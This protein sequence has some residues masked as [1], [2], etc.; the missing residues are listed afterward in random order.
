MQLLSRLIPQPSASAVGLDV[1]EQGL[2][3]VELRQS[4]AGLVL[5]RCG[6]EP[7]AP[8]CVVAG[9]VTE[10]EGVEAALRRL[11][12]AAGAAGH[13]G[14]KQTLAL[15]LAVPAEL[16][17]LRRAHFAGKPSAP[18]L[19]ELVQA[20]MASRLQLPP[21]EVCV[22]FQLGLARPA[23]PEPG[24]EVFAAA[25]PKELVE[26]RIALVEGA[27]LSLRPIVMAMDSQMAAL[28]ACRAIRARS[29][30]PGAAVAL[31][32]MGVD[33]CQ[34]DLIHQASIL[35]SERFALPPDGMRP[36]DASPE[37]C[38]GLPAGLLEAIESRQ[39]ADAAARPWQ[40]WVAG[41][42][43]EA[44]AWVALLQRRSSLP[45]G[46]LNPLDGMLR[47]EVLQGHGL[48]DASRTLV[49]CGLALAALDP[50]GAPA[51][52]PAG[53]SPAC[54]NFLPYRQIAVAQR[55][56]A[57]LLQ[58][59]AVALSVLLSSAVLWQLWSER[60]E[61]GQVAQ[62]E[63]RRESA[64]LDAEIRRL[65]AVAAEVAL[66]KRHEAA[67]ISFARERNQT[68]QMLHEL[69][70]LVPEGVQLISVRID[71]QGHASISG[72]AR[73]A[74]EVFG[75]IGR[76]SAG[77][78]FKQA[79]LLDLSS[80][81]DSGPAAAQAG[82][83]SAAPAASGSLAVSDA[84]VPSGPPLAPLSKPLSERAERVIFSLRA[85]P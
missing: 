57:L 26:D 61:A 67:L 50:P 5:E 25:V 52:S 34:L 38:H 9:Q 42:A 28:A 30:K 76:L 12:S 31:L 51:S 68:P 77:P 60:L 22:D 74:A 69:S 41:P 44:A 54:F 32:Q 75:L 4:Q 62:A 83:S 49:A 29:A 66:L 53:S 39:G 16:V 14:A 19:A 10:F 11:A 27:A 6:F 46:V 21:L 43:A 70:T 7:L 65:A 8:G 17:T 48:P 18:A 13:R 71:R 82:A 2:C 59:G 79:T 85:Q 33:G 36:S 64:E 55:Q 81:P 73:S 15:G 3:W 56:K 84:S 58:A 37:S 1:S 78:S 35:H 20:D 23:A 45:C 80:P 63:L 40:I 72:Q 47:G 24:T